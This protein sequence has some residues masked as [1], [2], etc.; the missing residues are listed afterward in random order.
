[1][2]A[3]LPRGLCVLLARRGHDAVHTFDLPAQNATKDRVINQISID[4]QRVVISKDTDFFYSH[5]LQDPHRS[6]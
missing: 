2:D 4:D 1:V 5:L 6:R 3:H